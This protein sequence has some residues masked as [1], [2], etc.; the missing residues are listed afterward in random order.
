MKPP[1]YIS[2]CV[3][4]ELLIYQI[5][6]RFPRL[7]L[8]NQTGSLCTICFTSKMIQFHKAITV[9]TITLAPGYLIDVYLALSYVN[10]IRVFTSMVI[11]NYEGKI[12]LWLF[13]CASNLSSLH[14]T[15]FI[16]ISLGEI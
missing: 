4:K 5:M 6:K 14:I 10:S 13:A 7:C 1:V 8:K 2:E 11:V 9:C 12:M 3:V 16:L 15:H